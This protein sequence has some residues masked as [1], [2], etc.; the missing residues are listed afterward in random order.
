[1]EEA[2]E[3]PER[4]SNLSLNF[5]DGEAGMDR[6]KFEDLVRRMK[7]LRRIELNWYPWGTLSDDLSRLPKLR[8]VRVMNS[9]LKEFPW[10]VW[11][12]PERL[13]VLALR[14]TDIRAVSPA[15]SRFSGLRRLDLHNNK[16]MGLP[17]EILTLPRIRTMNLMCNPLD[18]GVRD[19]LKDRFGRRVALSP[20]EGNS[21]D[22]CAEVER[23]ASQ[24]DES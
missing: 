8:E 9:V 24:R 2:E 17:R 4:V 7:R 19:Q 21:A 1:L 5:K 11:E 16:L 10:T 3:K 12:S 20:E 6:S 13:R 15:I 22:D 23:S 18:R 14:S